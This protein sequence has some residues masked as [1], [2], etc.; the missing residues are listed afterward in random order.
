MERRVFRAKPLDGK[1]T[2][3]VEYAKTRENT[4]QTLIQN[5][6]IFALS[7]FAFEE[8]LYLYYEMIEEIRPEEIFGDMESMLESWPEGKWTPLYE[9]FHFNKPQNQEQWARKNNFVPFATMSRIKPDLLSRYIFYHYQYQE[10]Y[11]SE[12]DKYGSIWMSG[13]LLFFYQEDPKVVEKAWYEGALTTRNTPKRPEQWSKTMAP[14]FLLWDDGEIYHNA[15]LLF[16]L[17]GKTDE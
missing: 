10:E 14:H 12:E 7:L 4:S 5:G 3:A 15:T 11:P 9:I 17:G 6:K 2:E 16:S 1:M 13:N 8:N